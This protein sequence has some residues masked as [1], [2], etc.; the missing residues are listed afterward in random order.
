M[1]FSKVYSNR[2][3]LEKVYSNKTMHTELAT[4]AGTK[5]KPHDLNLYSRTVL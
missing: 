2:T 5:I 3:I 1:Y 4:F